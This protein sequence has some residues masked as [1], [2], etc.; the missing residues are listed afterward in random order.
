MAIYYEQHGLLG[1]HASDGQQVW[2]DKHWWQQLCA[3]PKILSSLFV[4]N[5]TP[6][7][8]VPKLI[9]GNMDRPRL[10]PQTRQ[11]LELPVVTTC[12]EK[13]QH[14]GELHRSLRPRQR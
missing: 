14:H 5:S 8:D 6:I 3:R 1:S 4:E 11:L 7:P 9:L 12:H 13:V 10:P 2:H